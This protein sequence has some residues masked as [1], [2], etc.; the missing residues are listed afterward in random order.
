[1]ARKR[2][3]PAKP[4]FLADG[5]TPPAPT[6]TSDERLP[7]LS[8]PPIAQVAGEAAAHGALQALSADMERAR[9]EGLLLMRIPLKDIAPDHLAR[10]RVENADEDMRALCKSIF[11]RGQRTPI[12]VT[13]VD[14]T[15]RYGLISGWRRYHALEH[16]LAQT[17]DDKFASIIAV[18]RAP[19]DASDAYVSMVEENEVRVGLSYYERANVVLETVRR[20]VFEAEKQALQTLFASASRAKRSRIKAFIELVVEL[21]A[22]LSFPTAIPERFGLQ[23]IYAMRAD[24]GLA[25]MLRRDLPKAGPYVDGEREMEK[26]SALMEAFLK[27]RN[28]AV[29]EASPNNVP[30]AEHL[31]ETLPGLKIEMKGQRITISGRAVSEGLFDRLYQAL[32][33]M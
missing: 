12:E 5:H 32:K 8:G 16:L 3:T 30:H 21:G 10:D 25:E 14:G 2:L 18:L 19:K 4:E 28:R 24:D 27:Q 17:G 6:P 29:T 23:L 33:Q 31:R 1:M 13:Q 26:I 7:R 9:A 11:E 15:H 20:G 22:V